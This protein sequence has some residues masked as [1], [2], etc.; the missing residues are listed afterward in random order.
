[1]R[2]FLQRE[3]WFTLG[4][5]AMV[6]GSYLLIQRIQFS[7][8]TKLFLGFVAL[9]LLILLFGGAAMAAKKRE[10]AGEKEEV[11][12]E[13]RK[14]WLLGGIVRNIPANYAWVLRSAWGSNIDKVD[15]KGRRFGYKIRREGWNWYLPYLL[16][17]DVDC[18]DLSPQPR[19]PKAITVNTAD[20]QT[21]IIDWRIVTIV[22]DPALFA[23]KVNGNRIEFEDQAAT[24]FI[25]QRCSEETQQKLT[26]F[27]EG[28]LRK[29]GGEVRDR[30]NEEVENFLGI[31][32]EAIEI[33]K[34]LPP[35][36]VRTAAEYE[37]VTKRRKEVARHKGVELS[38]II[39]A[40]KSD[41]TKIVMMDMARD[42]VTNLVDIVV[43]AVRTYQETKNQEAKE[44]SEEK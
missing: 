22:S 6:L 39:E 23:V 18:V 36:E 7:T 34:I 25:N 33:Q 29:M 4:M 27:S 43:N 10:E 24:V 9:L 16:H 8:G 31:K 41:P 11:K 26:K 37:T 30:F 5:L 13:K 20:N 42:V 44:R 28:Q 2:E 35:E 40:T 17:I 14:D 1:M 19:D 12:E 32:A 21:A 15:K 38:R 3:G